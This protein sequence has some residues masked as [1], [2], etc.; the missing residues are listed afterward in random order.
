[1]RRKYIEKY[2]I[3]QNINLSYKNFERENF[4]MPF[5]DIILIMKPMLKA[6]LASTIKRC[7]VKLLDN[8]AVLTSVNSMGYK[9]LPFKMKKD[10]SAYITGSYIL[11]NC[12]LPF[13]KITECGRKRMYY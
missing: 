6:D 11:L 10:Q 1:M 3:F 2:I 12:A 4:A 5:Y 9:D 13:Q 7:C 8:G